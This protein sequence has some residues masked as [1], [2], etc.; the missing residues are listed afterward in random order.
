M[1]RWLLIG[2]GLCTACR[3]EIVPIVRR[4]EPTLP[5]RPRSAECNVHDY[6]GATDLPTDAKNIGWVEVPREAND[7]D[8]YKA[9]HAKICAGG[10]DA[11]SQLQWVKEP[12]QREPTSLRANAWVLP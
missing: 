6:P 8:T 12:G 5:S 1:T 11:M 7:E 4:A 3:T 9:L 2:F 10:G